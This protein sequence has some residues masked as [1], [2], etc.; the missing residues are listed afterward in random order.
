MRSRRA[1]ARSAR[2][3][4]CVAAL[5]VLACA[6][7]ETRESHALAEIGDVSFVRPPEPD[8]ELGDVEE[9]L[10]QLSG[11]GGQISII[12]FPAAMDLEAARE[13]LEV[14]ADDAPSAETLI[15]NVDATIG[16]TRRAGL[17][18]ETAGPPPRRTEIFLVP[19]GAATIAVVAEG[20]PGQ[21][22]FWGP[23]R[24]LLEGL[25]LPQ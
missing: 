4:S 1:R 10:I 24:Q 20:P 12:F 2:A 3:L 13:F 16:G 17:A 9:D 5:A 14:P 8:W 25:E 18:G 23:A 15:S 21:A 22:V 7:D 19:S 6:A 11:P